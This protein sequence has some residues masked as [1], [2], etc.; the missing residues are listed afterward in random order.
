MFVFRGAISSP[1]MPTVELF[2]SPFLFVDRQTE[3]ASFPHP[4]EATSASVVTKGTFDTDYII[5]S[6]HIHLCLSA[7]RNAS[8]F[9]V[10]SLDVILILTQYHGRTQE[11]EAIKAAQSVLLD[12]TATPPRAPRN[13]FLQGCS[14]IAGRILHEHGQNFCRQVPGARLML[15]STIKCAAQSTSGYLRSNLPLAYTF[16]FLPIHQGGPIRL[17]MW[18][19]FL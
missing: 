18:T 15:S 9:H 19:G 4:T 7:C 17:H 3:F 10:E 16:L 6:Q 13:A 1:D 12:P 5:L 14:G 2:F 11:Y 8:R